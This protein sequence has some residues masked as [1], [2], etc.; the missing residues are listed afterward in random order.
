MVTGGGALL[1]WSRWHRWSATSANDANFTDAADQRN[2]ASFPDC[3]WE[4]EEQTDGLT[5]WNPKK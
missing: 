4:V 2:L 1:Q 3:V 5:E